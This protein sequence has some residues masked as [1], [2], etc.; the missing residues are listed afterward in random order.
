MTG[1]RHI[2]V[3]IA[4]LDE[5]A[6]VEE[7]YARLRGAIASSP[8]TRAHFIWVV[9]GTDNT[10]R[11]LRSLPN[12][13]ELLSSSIIEPPIRRGLGAAFRIGFAAVPLHSD[14]VVTLDADLNHHPEE[15]KRLVDALDA[16][17]ADIAIGSRMVVGASGGQ[18]AW[19]RWLSN[20]ANRVLLHLS[21]S[22]VRDM[23]SG[24]RVYR[25]EALREL[26]FANDGFAFLPEIAMT[27]A[28]AGMKIVEVPITFSPRQRGKSKLNVKEATRSYLDL[29]DRRFRRKDRQG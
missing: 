4:A 28:D 22:T 24:Y 2:S 21:G 14:L 15:L 16:S 23:S 11:I 10:A 9:E 5:E 27:A 26:Q 8:N 7:L 6:N 12:E 13:D 17:Q 25:A 1:P 29:L 20:A 19:R 3:V 18:A